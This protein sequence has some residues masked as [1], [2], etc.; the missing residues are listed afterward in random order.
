[1]KKLL[2]PLAIIALLGL[3]CKKQSLEPASADNLET[4]SFEVRSSEALLN[5]EVLINFEKIEHKPAP[6]LPPIKW[7][8]SYSGKSTRS[9]ISRAHSYLVEYIINLQ[10]FLELYP[11][12]QFYYLGVHEEFIT[13][14]QSSL[15]LKQELEKGIE[16]LNNA[17][18]ELSRYQML[19]KIFED[20]DLALSEK[21]M[22][23][24]VTEDSIEPVIKIGRR[25][26]KAK[27][28]RD[29]LKLYIA[30]G[31]DLLLEANVEYSI[32]EAGKIE[33][34]KVVLEKI[35]ERLGKSLPEGTENDLEKEFEFIN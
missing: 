23:F 1:M 17:D 27:A 9:E 13:K 31:E 35:N 14:L 15:V 30:D 2:L 4:N 12:E 33:V 22:N 10:D 18:L 29:Q 24:E 26:K 34:A 16:K 32:L 28:L 25:K 8:V 7:K 20:M 19:Q 3:S 11:V 5:K 21:G 6:G